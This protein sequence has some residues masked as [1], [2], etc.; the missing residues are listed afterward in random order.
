[1][2]DVRGCGFFEFSKI[3]IFGG[4]TN[5]SYTVFLRGFSLW[6]RG[7]D[8]TKQIMVY[9][10]ITFFIKT[11]N[12]YFFIFFLIFLGVQKTLENIAKSAE[13]ANLP[14]IPSNPVAYQ[15]RGSL[16]Y[17]RINEKDR[18]QWHSAASTAVNAASSS[19]QNGS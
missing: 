12:L 5:V 3:S 10:Q 17:V 1:M 4:L 19:K 6:Q 11:S 18:S 2:F 13:N 9:D 15:P 16:S 8:S 7:I 14:G